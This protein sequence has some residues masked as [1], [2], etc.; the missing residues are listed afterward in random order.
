MGPFYYY[1]DKDETSRIHNSWFGVSSDFVVASY[2]W[3]GRG[4]RY[5]GGVL[6]GQSGFG[7]FT[8][9]ALGWGGFRLALT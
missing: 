6:A 7:R 3:F 5:T 1:K 8:G 2:P 9:G 4:G